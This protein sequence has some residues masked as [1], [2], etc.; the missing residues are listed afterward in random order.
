[1][2]NAQPKT[3]AELLRAA[4][5]LIETT[6][7]TQGTL[8]R[9]IR[10]EPVGSSD[11]AASCFCGYGAVSAVSALVGIN[12]R[13]ADGAFDL[14]DKAAEQPFPH[15]NDTKDRTKEEVLA[16]FDEAIALAESR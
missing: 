6:G 7:W 4:K 15:F 3:P 11:P 1:M 8:A 13:A 9:D 10:G 14:L 16:K 12:Y 2:E 5:A